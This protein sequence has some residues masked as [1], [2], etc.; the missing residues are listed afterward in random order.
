MFSIATTVVSL[1]DSCFRG[2]HKSICEHIEQ[3]HWITSTEQVLPPKVLATRMNAV[4]N[5]FDNDVK[6]MKNK[7]KG[8]DAPSTRKEPS[9]Q[10]RG[11][12]STL[13]EPTPTG[14][15]KT[16][17][18]ITPREGKK[19]PEGAPTGAQGKKEKAEARRKEK[20]EKS[21]SIASAVTNLPK[22]AGGSEQ[23][24]QYEESRKVMEDY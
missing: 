4:I 23:N 17:R 6:N 3:R 20:A 11:D 9:E 7:G 1:E 24:I 10:G 21:M 12:G 22:D 18:K 14:R 16:K 8:I 15:S 2:L 13:I 19:E 5:S